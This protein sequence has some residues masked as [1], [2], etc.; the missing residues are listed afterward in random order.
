MV[1]ILLIWWRAALTCCLLA[2][3]WL[4]ELA[5]LCLPQQNHRSEKEKAL[6]GWR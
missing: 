6:N 5:G 2:H 4:N 1:G 3:Q